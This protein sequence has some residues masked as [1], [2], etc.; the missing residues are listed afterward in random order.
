MSTFLGKRRCIRVRER[1]QPDTKE[2]EK[3]SGRQE[4]PSAASGLNGTAA[5]EEDQQN[6]S[7]TS[8]VNSAIDS[9]DSLLV[10]PDGTQWTSIVPGT[11]LKG[12]YSQQNILRECPAATF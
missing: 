7:P 1:L 2:G 10:S 12:R 4:E 3:L 11:Y 6:Q 5:C 8:I 9:N